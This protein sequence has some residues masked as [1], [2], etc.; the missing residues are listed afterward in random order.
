MSEVIQL[1]RE[2]PFGTLIVLLSAIW[3]VERIAVY[4]LKVSRP[5]ECNCPCKDE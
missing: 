4:L 2:N 5:V 1:A 3:A